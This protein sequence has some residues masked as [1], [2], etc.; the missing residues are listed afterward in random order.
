MAWFA[1]PI[2]GSPTRAGTILGTA[3]YMSPE[4]WRGRPVDARTD[5]FSFG[6][7]LYEMLAGRRP[8]TGNTDAELV[9]AIL[10]EDPPELAAS[11]RAI[12]LELQRIVGRCLD[13]NPEARFQ[14]AR[15]LAFALRSVG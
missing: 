13:K 1:Q 8:F 15:D 6:C 10:H 4:Q 11:E 9:A 12:P 2:K 3:P 5:F 7:V 14:S